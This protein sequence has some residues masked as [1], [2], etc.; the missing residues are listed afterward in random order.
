MNKIMRKLKKLIY[1]IGLLI[2]F[3]ALVVQFYECFN[4]KMNE[5]NIFMLICN[6]IIL[7][8]MCIIIGKVINFSNCL[9]SIKRIINDDSLTDKQKNKYISYKIFDIEKDLK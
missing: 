6:C 7:Y 3:M 9:V 4:H 8:S 2:L 5:D 1:E